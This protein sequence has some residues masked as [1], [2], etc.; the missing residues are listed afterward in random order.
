M[1]ANKLL[2]LGLGVKSPWQI[3]AHRLCTDSD[4]FELEIR[5]EAECESVFPCPERGCMCKAHNFK[6]L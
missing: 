4:S 2:S 6:E 3:V 5:L 1:H